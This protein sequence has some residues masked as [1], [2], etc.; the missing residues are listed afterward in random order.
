MRSGV[1]QLHRVVLENITTHKPLGKKDMEITD[2]E[3][4]DNNA[5][6]PYTKALGYVFSPPCSPDY[7]MYRQLDVFLPAEPTELHFDPEVVRFMVTSPIWGTEW[8]K[9]RHPWQGKEEHPVIP[10]CMFIRDRVDKVVEAFTFGGDLHILTEEELTRCTLK[11]PAPI[12][13]LNN[14]TSVTTIFAEEVEIQLAERRAVWDVA[15]PKVPFEEQLA[16]VD[17]FDLYLAC[18]EEFQLKF[19]HLPYLQSESMLHFTHF[20]RLEIRALHEMHR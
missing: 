15:H 7:P 20:I 17:P 16:K 12:L 18:L 4:N 10:S 8:I 2:I 9:V 5:R 1:K 3:R 14:G 13:P 11:S 19:F 6:L